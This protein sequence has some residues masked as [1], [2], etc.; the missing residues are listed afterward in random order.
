MIDILLIIY[1]YHKQARKY[2][3]IALSDVFG[4]G[5][6]ERLNIKSPAIHLCFGTEYQCEASLSCNHA[7]DM[8]SV[9]FCIL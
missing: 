9:I 7:A 8:K 1:Q 4:G 3:Y 2:F 5:V 6:K